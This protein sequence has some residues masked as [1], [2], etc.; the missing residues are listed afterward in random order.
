M[1]GAEIHLQWT[2]ALLPL[3]VLITAGLGLGFGLI[4]SALTTKYRDLKFLIQFGIQL[5]MYATPVIYPISTISEKNQWIV[6][7][8]PMT[9]I[10]EAFKFSFLGKGLFTFQG[11]AY[12]FIIMLLILILGAVIFNRTEKNF[13]DTV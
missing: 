12:S 4:I 7:L 13:M 8:N 10:V 11:L 5:W 2:V 1:N 6:L 9:S 3:Y